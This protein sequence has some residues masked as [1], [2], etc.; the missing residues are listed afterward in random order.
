MKLLRA[1]GILG[2]IVLAAA[3]ISGVIHHHAANDHGCAACVWQI[4]GTAV[5]PTLITT[6]APSLV[7]VLP[8][9]TDAPVLTGFLSPSTASRAPPAASA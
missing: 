4:S 9:V 1:A 2:L 6:P 5:V 3:V 8:V 7:A